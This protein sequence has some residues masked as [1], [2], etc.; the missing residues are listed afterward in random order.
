MRCIND[1]CSALVVS[2][3]GKD[4]ESLNEDSAMLIGLLCLVIFCEAIIKLGRHSSGKCDL[5]ACSW[6]DR[7]T[8]QCACA[9][10]LSAGAEFVP[11]PPHSIPFF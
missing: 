3:I 10:P 6:S 1:R 7:A 4:T 2:E 8:A 11:W 9:A 5:Q